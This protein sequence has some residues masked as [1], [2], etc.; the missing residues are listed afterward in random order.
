MTEKIDQ[1]A[2]AQAAHDKNLKARADGG[3]GSGPKK[4]SG[5]GGLKE[6]LSK[7]VGE[8][9]KEKK[10]QESRKKLRKSLGGP[11]KK[12]RGVPDF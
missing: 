3:M 1:A 11:T 10:F 2:M 5:T 4:G 9:A 12:I 6:S 8:F 7:R